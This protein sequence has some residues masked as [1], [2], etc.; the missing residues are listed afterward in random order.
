MEREVVRTYW[1][2]RC[3]YSG[4]GYYGDTFG[5]LVDHRA[6]ALRFTSRAEAGTV[7]CAAVEM[8]NDDHPV[9]VTVYRKRA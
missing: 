1:V 8:C 2:I 9:K 5:N 3:G 6:N 4:N 7:M